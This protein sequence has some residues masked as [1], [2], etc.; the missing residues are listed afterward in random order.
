VTVDVT[1]AVKVDQVEYVLVYV[2]PS[3]TDVVVTGQMV[4]D[5]VTTSVMVVSFGTHVVGVAV[6]TW[7]MVE[8]IGTVR[9]DQVE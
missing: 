1:G 9:V 2:V 5:T 7:V 3:D 8:V 4:D 6:T